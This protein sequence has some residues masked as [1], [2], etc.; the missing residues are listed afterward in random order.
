MTFD[1]I[2]CVNTARWTEFT[3]HFCEK[4]DGKVVDRNCFCRAVEDDIEAVPFMDGMLVDSMNVFLLLSKFYS[5]NFYMSNVTIFCNKKS[6][7]QLANRS[8]KK[9]GD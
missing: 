8:A 4:L 3:L 7:V 9:K 5:W 6:T 1:S 2:Q